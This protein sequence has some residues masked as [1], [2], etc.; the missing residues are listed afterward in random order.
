MKP[1]KLIYIAADI[2]HKRTRTMVDTGSSISAINTSYATTVGLNHSIKPITASCR[3]ANNGQL[4]I[5]GVITAHITIN[6]CVT[7]VNLFVIDHLCVDLLLGGDFCLKYKVGIDYDQQCLSFTLDHYRIQA[8]FLSSVPTSQTFAV[9]SSDELV[10]PPMS[11]RVVRAT[12]T[13]PSMAA[14]FTPTLHHSHRQVVAPHAIVTVQTDH[15][16]VLTILNPSSSTYR[17]PRHTTLG[18]L[19]THEPDNCFSI[20]SDDDDRSN[21]PLSSARTSIDSS[22]STECDKL[23]SHLSRH[24]QISVRSILRKHSNLFDTSISSIMKTNGF[25][26]RVPVQPHHP[27][28]QSY[29]YRKSAKESTVINEQVQDMLSNHVIRPSTSPWSSPV[30]LIQKKDGTPRFCVDYRRLNLITERDVYPLPRIDDIIDKLA[31]SR[32][33]STLDLK[34]GYWQIPVAEDD[35]KKTAFI[36]TDGLYEFNVLPFGL[37][38]APATFQRVINSVLGSL[39]WDIT[40]VYLD[41]IIVYSPSFDTHVQHLDRVLTALH[42]ANVRLNITKCS[43]ARKQLDY[44][45]FRITEHGIKPTTTNVKK[46]LDF[47]TPT[48]TKAAYSFVQ[49]AQFYR[50]FIRD[51]SSIAAPLHRFKNK[52]VP[53]EWSNECQ[54]SF[55]TLKQ[56]LSQYP[57]LAFYDGKSPLKLKVNTDASN[58]GIGGVLHQM[59]EDGRLQPIQYVSRS[60]STREQKYSTVEKECLAMVWCVTKLRPYLYG[61]P[62][63]LITDHHPL[64]WLNKQSSKNGRL[65]RWSLQ[66]QEY[67]FDIKHTPGPSNCVADCL[68]RYPNQ[69]PDNAADELLDQLHGQV[70]AITTDNPNFFDVTKL[71]SAQQ[72]DLSIKRIFDDL[73]NG[74]TNGP[75]RFENN[76]VHRIIRRPNRALHSLPYIPQSMVSSLLHAYHNSP[77]SGHLGVSK[78]WNRIRDRYYWPGMYATIKRYVLSCGSCQRFKIRRTKPAGTLEPIEPPT[79]VLDLMGLDFVGP[80]PQSANG[81][82][83]ILVCTDYLSRYAITQATADCSAETAAKFLVECVLLR[84]GVPKLLL[85][86]RG[87]HFMSNVFEAIA[88]RC[89][90]THITSTAYHPQC[91]GLTERFNATLVNS[92]ATY[93]N[94]QQSD[95]DQF[96]PFATFAY[97]TAQQSTTSI[98]PFTLMYGRRP[99]LP[100]DRPT[101]PSPISTPNDYY[102]SLLQYLNYARTMAWRQTKKQQDI[103]KR[104]YDTGRRDL[105]PLRPGQLIMLQQMMPKNLKKFS[106]KYYGPFRVVKQS[107]R[108]NYEVQ[109]VTGGRIEKVHVSR[110]RLIP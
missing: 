41:D 16:A 28:I 91:N 80:I 39:R 50:R 105:A 103:Y 13:S 1:S 68:S 12:T 57:L 45:G 65:D 26:H 60:L 56:K 8:K 85:T 89:G 61:Q 22:L 79:G 18:Y 67:S 62:F 48:S 92:I 72:H 76:I 4:V 5:R 66:L 24:E 107:S 96:L 94:Q 54:Q 20:H 86:D 98:E 44:L 110:I 9:S 75:Y 71:A 42:A 69:P 33:F 81:L 46:T 73:C 84:F 17:L 90:I 3:T 95:W 25:Y 29:P 10:L 37:S 93:V 70:S 35:K 51:F 52:N 27:P 83:Y 59:G 82:K 47:P 109:N 87:S 43:I 32:Y 99:V 100:F 78:T 34:A 102:A 108:L 19:Q 53:F 38:N 36:T 64:C 74:H 58:I 14:I 40:L 55:D 97:N 101:A 63:T 2:G 21:R 15:T 104:S 49:M 31:G 77:T 88:S 30:V 7:S 23:I 11:S 6:N 106:P